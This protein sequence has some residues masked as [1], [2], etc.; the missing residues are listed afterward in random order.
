MDARNARSRALAIIGLVGVI[1][2][3]AAGAHAALT[4]HGDL[5]AW[6]ELNAAFKKLMAL[7]S[8][9]VTVKSSG[10]TST[11]IEIGGPHS[12]H[13]LS[14][15]ITDTGVWTNEVFAVD[16]QIRKRTT[17]VPGV[18]EEWQCPTSAPPKGAS[19]KG[20]NFGDPF[21]SKAL[22]GM[23]DMSRGP[24]TVI[25]GTSVRTYQYLFTQSDTQSGQTMRTTDI[26]SVGKANGLPR[27]I[28]NEGANGD[29]T[30]M[31]DF[32]DFGARI[33]MTLPRCK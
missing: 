2:F 12:Y 9:R 5:A 13:L 4:V 18:P 31:T 33:V 6:K 29:V 14:R 27:R 28:V 20:V 7:S 24:D 26:V 25:E 10:M 23:V 15:T 3:A 16:G 1:T 17:G 22:H 21:E 8:Y 19:L 30:G 32:D 11:V